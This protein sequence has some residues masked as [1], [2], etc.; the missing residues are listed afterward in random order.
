MP[1]AGAVCV[2]V[3]ALTGWS[4]VRLCM[5]T[6]PV[7]MPIAN[8]PGMSMNRLFIIKKQQDA[9]YYSSRINFCGD[10]CTAYAN[11][12]IQ[13]TVLSPSRKC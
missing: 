1:D 7:S 11:P 10:V 13:F 12:D 3:G 5:I 4:G 2:T 6:I 9:V 8:R